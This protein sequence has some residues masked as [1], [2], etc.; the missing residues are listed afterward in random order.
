MFASGYQ[1][2][3]IVLCTRELSRMI[4][5]AGIDFEQLP[6]EEADSILGE[7]AGAGVIF[8]ATGGVMEAAL[9]TAYYLITGTDLEKVEFQAVRGLQGVKETEVDIQG[10]KIRIAVA[11]GLSNV[12]YV[13]SKVREAKEAHQEP[14]L[15]L[16]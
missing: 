9:R 10:K 5:Q 3:D 1:D 7:Y 2:I 16:Y 13:I 14:A 8:G 11:Q 15:S 6:Q 12:E 4:K